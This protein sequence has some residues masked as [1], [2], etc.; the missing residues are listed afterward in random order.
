MAHA[1]YAD[2]DLRR[3][4]TTVNAIAMVGASANP[5]RPS[6]GVLGFLLAKGF[7]VHPVNPGH[8]GKDIQ[9]RRVYATL[10]EVPE[11]IDMVDV[12]R[13]SSQVA[14]VVNEVLA[15][16]PLPRVI[17]M[18]LGVRDDEAAARAEAAGIE[19]VMDRCPKI[20]WGRLGLQRPMAV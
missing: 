9:G 1:S 14:G 19:V 20:E 6:Y 10:A 16:A 7:R 12:F 2:A 8:A 15:L 13:A 17:W 11:A 5:A 4:L 3:I 18:Q